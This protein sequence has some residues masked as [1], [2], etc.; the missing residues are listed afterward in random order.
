MYNTLARHSEGTWIKSRK[1]L[2]P[3]FFMTVSVSHVNIARAF[4][5]PRHNRQSLWQIIQTLPQNERHATAKGERKYSS[6]SF[7]TSVLDGGEW[8]AS[9][10][11][12]ALPPE[13]GP[14]VPIGQEAG[15]A[16]ELVLDTEVRGKILCLCRGS[17]P[18][19]PVCSQTLWLSST[20]NTNT[21]FSY[22]ML[23]QVVPIVPTG[24]SRVNPMLR[25]QANPTPF[26]QWALEA[27]SPST[28]R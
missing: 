23:N 18:G 22:W 28:Y 15:W 9:R 12:R 27:P 8:S 21:K 17:N 24:F 20:W 3:I 11:G 14:P 19:R 2:P 1:L 10:P 4:Q 26:I 6:Y 16:S 25:L 13:K 5:I 7:L